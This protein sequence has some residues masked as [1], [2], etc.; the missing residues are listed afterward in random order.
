MT[1]ATGP[2]TATS[3]TNPLKLTLK[4][5]PYR[6]SNLTRILQTA[7]GGN[8]KTSMIAAISPAADNYE[9]TISTLRYADQVKKIKNTAII[10][11]TPQDKLIRA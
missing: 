7:L 2:M 1:T 9:E 5:I 4:H 3:E 10:N 11:E 8:S 6:E